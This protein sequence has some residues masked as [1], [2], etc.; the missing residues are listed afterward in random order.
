MVRGYHK[1]KNICV[2]VV[3]EELSCRREPTN[4]EDRFVVAVLKDSN[5][6]GHIPR[7]ISSICSLFLRQSGNIICLV[8]GSRQYSSDL[9]QGGLEI[10]CMLTFSCTA[11]DGNHLEKIRRLIEHDLSFT[12]NEVSEPE[13]SL[14]KVMIEA[15]E[16]N[17]Q[18]EE[19][20]KCNSDNGSA[21]KSGI[22]TNVPVGITSSNVAGLIMTSCVFP[23]DN[24]LESQDWLRTGGIRLTRENKSEILRGDKLN[25]LVINFVQK[26]LKK[27]FPLMK[28][29]Q[30]TLM[31]YKSPKASNNG[32]APQVQVIHCRGHHWIFALTVYGGSFENV[33]IY[34]SLFDTIDVTS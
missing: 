14:S 10:P 21:T 20:N 11:K 34:D 4:W 26:L 19:D 17:N 15:S 1:Y 30:S 7:K 32:S 5:V 33:Q 24:K 23:S 28:G 22:V 8:T 6:V 25:D 2:A 16:S 12:L 29:L 3:D 18:S 27:Q 9:P 31:Q 13:D